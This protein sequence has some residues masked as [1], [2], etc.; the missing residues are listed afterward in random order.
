[1][2]YGRTEIE[3]EISLAPVLLPFFAIKDEMYELNR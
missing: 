1:M 2:V 3:R